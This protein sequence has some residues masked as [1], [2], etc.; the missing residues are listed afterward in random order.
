MNGQL[1]L[2]VHEAVSHDGRRLAVKVQHA[3]LREACNADLA[4]IEFL[5]QTV[6]IFFPVRHERDDGH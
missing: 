5:V 1:T 4:T 2:Q 3:G 6:R